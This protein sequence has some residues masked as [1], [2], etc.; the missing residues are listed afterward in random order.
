[1]LGL[2]ME[3]VRRIPIT[4]WREDR[5]EEMEDLVAREIPLT[6][7]V[8]GRELA[9]LLCS[10]QGLRE[11]CLGFLLSE[12]ILGPE[13]PLPEIVIAEPGGYAQ[14]TLPRPLAPEFSQALSRLVGSGC[15]AS[16]DFYRSADAQNA[17]P[18]Q[19]QVA[20]PRRMI[21]ELMKAFQAR[22]ELYRR[23]G[24]VHAAAL[25]T[26]GGEIIAFSED[27]GR[28]NALDRIIGSAH[29]KRQSLRDLVLLTSGRLSSEIVIKAV[30][31]GLPILVS[32]SAPTDLAAGLAQKLG[33]TLAGFAR[34]KRLNVYSGGERIR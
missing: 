30:K 33:L 27:I 11:L 23:T 1:M 26:A 5:A 17:R 34:G 22:S 25:A 2:I 9:T 14:V 6:I 7:L 21:R 29:L 12:G 24:G 3:M 32:R 31:A 10:P 16:A 4:R 15:A 20:I 8:N 19:S 13:E 28:H 18:V